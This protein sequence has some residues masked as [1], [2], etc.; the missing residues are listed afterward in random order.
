[1]AIDAGPDE[2]SRLVTLS[3]M[4]DRRGDAARLLAQGLKTTPNAVPLLQSQ[5]RLLGSAGNTGGANPDGSPAPSLY[6]AVI[7]KRV[8]ERTRAKTS[9]NELLRD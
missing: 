8:D 2:I 3:L 6:C 1:M 9:I 5:A 4:H 7:V